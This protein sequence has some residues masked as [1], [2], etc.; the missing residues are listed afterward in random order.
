MST[1]SLEPKQQ[2]MPQSAI[3]DMGF[4]SGPAFGLLRAAAEFLSKADIIPK[5]FQGNLSNCAVALN[6]AQRMGADPLMVMQNLYVVYGRPSWSAQFLI[7]TMNTKGE[8]S[9]LRYEWTDETDKKKDGFGCRACATELATGESLHGPWVTVGLARAEGWYSRESKTGNTA[10][11]WPT[12]TELMCMYRAAAFF[13]RTYCPEIA[14]GLRTS[15]EEEE[16]HSA[17]ATNVTAQ[18][19]VV[20]RKTNIPPTYSG[21][22]S[23]NGNGDAPKLDALVDADKTPKEIANPSPAAP[24]STA[25]SPPNQTSKPKAEQPKAAGTAGNPA[26]SDREEDP[27]KSGEL[28]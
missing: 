25:A 13:V 15:D 26:Y 17:S 3:K 2:T 14:M 8:F 7:A 11:K 24:Q 5:Q 16:I 21:P 10:S 12:L 9:K 18:G 19:E 4:H 27:F 28:T 23:E 1:Q 20:E 22:I 6:M